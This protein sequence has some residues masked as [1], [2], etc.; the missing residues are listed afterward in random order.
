[1]AEGTI[2]KAL[3]GFYY[4]KSAGKTYQCRARGRFRHTNV[5]PLVGDRVEFTAAGDAG[6]VVEILPRKNVFQ[7][8]PVANMDLMVLMAANVIPVTEPFLID[9][10]SVIARHKGIDVVICI[11]KCDLDPGDELYSIY[12]SAGFTVIRTSAVTGE[13][14]DELSA[15]LRGRVSVFSGNSGVG[16]SCVLNAL[17]PSFS[18]E[19]GEVSRK[20]GRGRHTTRHVELFETR[21]G[22]VIADTPGFSAFDVEKMDL[23]CAGDLEHAFP[24]FE[25]FIPGCRFTG[26]SHTKE[27][28]CAVLEAVRE[29]LVQPSRHRSYVRLYEQLKSVKSWEKKQ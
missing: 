22:A 17:D 5:T 6:T 12:T 13:G 19:T 11:N 18:I 24:E 26:C 4:V 3:S 27:S 28:G 29:G 2:F 7:R 14:I 25:K 20:L 1:M 15:V 10:M 23:D 16:K 8:P 9:R 21:G